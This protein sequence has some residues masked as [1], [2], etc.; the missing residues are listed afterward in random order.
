MPEIIEV[1][2]AG[3]IFLLL[4]GTPEEIAEIPVDHRMMAHIVDGEGLD[5][6]QD[7]RGLTVDVTDG[8]IAFT[9]EAEVG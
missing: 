7:L 1:I 2:G 5:D 9:S 6:P 8:C 4:L 3:S